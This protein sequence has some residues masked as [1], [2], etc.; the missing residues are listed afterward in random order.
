MRWIWLLMKCMVSFRPNRGQGYFLNFLGAPV[1]LYC[2]KCIS[3]GECYV[4]LI[5]FSCLFLS[6]LLITSEV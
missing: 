5:M 2:K 6:F 1:I 3:L 4:V